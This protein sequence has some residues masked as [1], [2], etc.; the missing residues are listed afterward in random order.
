MDILGQHEKNFPQE[1]RQTPQWESS[2]E[3]GAITRLVVRF[4]GGRIENEWH[5]GYV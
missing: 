3:Y 1:S 4:S 5:G 2:E